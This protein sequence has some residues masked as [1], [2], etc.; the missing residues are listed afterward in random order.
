MSDNYGINRPIGKRFA[1]KVWQILEDECGAGEESASDFVWWAND[2]NSM[3]REYR[4]CGIFGMAG[5]IWIGPANIRVTGPN[6]KEYEA[7]GKK[8]RDE[9]KQAENRAN[10]LL[11]ELCANPP[12]D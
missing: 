7:M 5:K 10:E 6:R 2:S 12:S 8:R 1:E 9:L 3:G 11:D 4:F